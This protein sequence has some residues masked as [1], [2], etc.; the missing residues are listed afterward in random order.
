MKGRPF[1]ERGV[2]ECQ[3]RTPPE[4]STLYVD[5]MKSVGMDE[6]APD[7]RYGIISGLPVAWRRGY[8][9]PG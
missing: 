1:L 3:L 5:G 6:I 4:R 7:A 8:S 9:A 2:F